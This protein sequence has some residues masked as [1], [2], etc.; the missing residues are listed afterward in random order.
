MAVLARELLQTLVVVQKLPQLEAHGLVCRV[1]ISSLHGL[2]WHVR[3]VHICSR[4]LKVVAGDA[5]FVASRA[6]A[7]NVHDRAMSEI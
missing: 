5:L 2:T 7:V 3:S 1:G 4:F 6:H